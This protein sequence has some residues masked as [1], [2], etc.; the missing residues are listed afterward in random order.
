MPLDRLGEVLERRVVLSLVRESHEAGHQVCK[1]EKIGPKV[2]HV[3]VWM[4]SWE[5]DE[6]KVRWGSPVL[7]PCFGVLK[8]VAGFVDL[9]LVVR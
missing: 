5:D 7:E 1:H 4:S 6:G 9:R 2:R 3:L 8:P